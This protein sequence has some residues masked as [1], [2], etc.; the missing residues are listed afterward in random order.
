MTIRSLVAR[1]LW[2]VVAALSIGGCASPLISRPL[3]SPRLFT[4]DSGT[5]PTSI[6]RPAPDRSRPTLVVGIPQASAGYDTA[7]IVYLRRPQE[8][9]YFAFNQWVDTP[10]N[11]L[12]PLLVRAFEGSPAFQAV[13]IAPSAALAQL[14]LDTEIIRL[15]QDFSRAPSQVRLTVRAVLIDAGNR[16]VIAER[17]FDVRVP[18]PSDDPYGGVLAARMA[19]QRIVDQVA[20]FCATE[21][22]R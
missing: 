8:I 12:G 9:E 10:S 4:L 5:V 7:H 16:S 14:R 6:S 11:M 22:S 20:A 1:P 21:T 3:S 2:A 13:V 18:S 19:T 15:E 17:T